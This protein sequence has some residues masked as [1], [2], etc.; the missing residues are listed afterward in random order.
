MI[1]KSVKRKR[2]LKK[3]VK[4]RQL[5]MM[6]FWEMMSNKQENDLHISL[7]PRPE[8][9]IKSPPFYVSS[10]APKDF[11]TFETDKA[12]NPF[13]YD[14]FPNVPDLLNMPIA[15]PVID[16]D[17]LT[18]KAIVDQGACFKLMTIDSA[19]YK[20]MMASVKDYTLSFFLT[21]DG[22]INLDTLP[23]IKLDASDKLP[24][25]K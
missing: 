4:S 8:N 9:W 12:K 17:A 21:G 22:L 3:A 6:A 15:S 11:N 7:L 16:M 14:H 10:R 25:S 13:F 5:W 18:R 19:E 1:S 20:E 2:R 23:Q 24:K